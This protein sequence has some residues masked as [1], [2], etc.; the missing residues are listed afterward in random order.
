[1]VIHLAAPFNRLARHNCSRVVNMEYLAF[2]K[3]GRHDRVAL[4]NNR[5]E[6]VHYYLRLVIRLAVQNDRLA[7][8]QGLCTTLYR[9]HGQYQLIDTVL[10]GYRAVTVVVM[11]RL[12]NTQ[13]VQVL[14][15]TPRV[16]LTFTDSY[17]LYEVENRLIFR[18]DQTPDV[19]TSGL[20][21]MRRVLV[22]TR[23]VDRVCLRLAV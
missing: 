1:M 9:L 11:D 16:I 12:A 22:Q 10:V 3:E 21:V 17:V 13:T 14:T 23:C 20:G 15:T 8:T 4:V 19:V 7:E 5:G 2:L 18:Q 6:R